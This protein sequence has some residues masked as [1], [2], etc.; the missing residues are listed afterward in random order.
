MSHDFCREYL[1]RI[2]RTV[3]NHTT[4]EQRNSVWT[5]KCGLGSSPKHEF[6]G[7]DG[8]YW[9]GQSCCKWHARTEGWISWLEHNVVSSLQLYMEEFYG[10]TNNGFPS[11]LDLSL[12]DT[13]DT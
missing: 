10:V 12:S 6:H 13:R 5:W 1:K 3:R 11:K 2:M 4:L 9:Y 8:F 7:P